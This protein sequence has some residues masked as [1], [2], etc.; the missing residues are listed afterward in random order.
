M[1]RQNVNTQESW[2]DICILTLVMIFIYW[3]VTLQLSISHHL[4]S[5]WDKISCG[6][7]R[8]SQGPHKGC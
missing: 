1:T 7:L 6:G 4:H 2:R 5:S 8:A 3:L